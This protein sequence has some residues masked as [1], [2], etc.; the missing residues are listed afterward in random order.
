MKI[1]YVKLKVISC[2]VDV[3]RWVFRL[4]LRILKLVCNEKYIEVKR[5][6]VK[7]HIEQVFIKRTELQEKIGITGA[8]AVQSMERF[9]EA[10]KRAFG[11]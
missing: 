5:K 3:S 7:K 4:Y 8:D 2:R 11:G 10:A 6:H 1:Y 9:A